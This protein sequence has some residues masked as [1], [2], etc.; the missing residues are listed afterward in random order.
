LTRILVV[1]GVSLDSIVYLDQLPSPHPQTIFSKGFHETVGS[2]GA[3]KA[4]T[5]SRLG[6]DVTFHALI[7]DDTP[8]Q[9]ILDTFSREKL[10]FLHEI[11][12]QGT[13]RHINL[14]DEAGGRISS[15]ASHASFEPEFDID[16]LA[17]EIERCDI[18]V[19][20]IIN[21]C[22][23]LIPL[24]Q[25][26]H[27]PIWCDIHDYDGEND[28]HHDFIEAASVIFMSSDAMPGYRAFMQT[29]IDGGKQLVGCTHGKHGATAVTAENDWLDIP[30]VAYPQVDTNGTGDAFFAGYLWG[31]LQDYSPERCLQLAAITGGLTVTTR[32]IAFPDLSVQRLEQAWQARFGA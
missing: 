4:L 31:Y 27:R 19:L 28:Y 8:G 15:Y 20:N 24:A 14:M 12:S 9:R 2:T 32:E 3:G 5:L 25:K 10:R 23:Q 1:G 29:L 22:R 21:Y 7:G 17:V 16:R 11:D 6:V 13:E 18:L 26:Y 30:A